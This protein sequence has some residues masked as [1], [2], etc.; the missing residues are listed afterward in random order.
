MSVDIDFVEIRHGVE[1]DYFVDCGHFAVAADGDE[2]LV[3]FVEI[4]VLV[5]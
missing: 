5:R 1:Y 3:Y 2:D 4:G